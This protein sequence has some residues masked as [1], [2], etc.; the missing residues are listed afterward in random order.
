[1]VLDRER[2][3]PYMSTC[4]LRIKEPKFDARG[5]DFGTR[6]NGTGLWGLFPLGNSADVGAGLSGP[7]S[8]GFDQSRHDKTGREILAEMA[9]RC[10]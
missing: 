3:S 7:V 9:L 4:K 5:R 6:R 2:L 1:M 10:P 8:E